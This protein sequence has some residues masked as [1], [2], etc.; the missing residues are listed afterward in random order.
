[1]KE[2][3]LYRNDFRNRDT[4][5]K[6]LEKLEIPKGLWFWTCSVKIKGASTELY[7]A[8]GDLIVY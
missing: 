3:Y 1:M 2:V 5:E 7:S 6:F 8:N 4:F